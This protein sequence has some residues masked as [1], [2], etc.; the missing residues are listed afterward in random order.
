MKPFTLV[1]KNVPTAKSDEAGRIEK[2]SELQGYLTNVVAE[3]M[4]EKI[5]PS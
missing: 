3:M 2:A 5:A 1:G 4:K